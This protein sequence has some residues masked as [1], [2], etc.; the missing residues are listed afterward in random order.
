MT[1]GPKAVT[2]GPKAVTEGSFFAS[3]CGLA[4]WILLVLLASSL[5]GVGLAGVGLAGV[6][7]AGVGLAGIGRQRLVGLSLQKAGA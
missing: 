3:Q 7:L 2:E 6:G 1:E 5:A 4:C